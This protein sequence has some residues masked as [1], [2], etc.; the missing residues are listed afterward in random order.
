MQDL[1]KY[2]ARTKCLLTI[3]QC[4]TCD[5]GHH[6]RCYNIDLLPEPQDK[7]FCRECTSCSIKKP[8]NQRRKSC[9]IPRRK[10]RRRESA[11]DHSNKDGDQNHTQCSRESESTLLSTGSHS[12]GYALFISPSRRSQPLNQTQRAAPLVR[13]PTTPAPSSRTSIFYSWP[14][15]KSTTIDINEYACASPVTLLTQTQRER[16]V[17]VIKLGNS[18]GSRLLRMNTVTSSASLFEQ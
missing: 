13:D 7:W 4:S 17:L 2:K 16:I 18:L 15:S 14:P 9:D 1:E 8:P 10:K 12:E 3:I 11:P 6:Q 5:T